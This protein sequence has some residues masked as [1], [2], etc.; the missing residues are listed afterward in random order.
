MRR[1]TGT[2]VYTYV[3][4][5]RAAELDLHEDRSRR[6]ALREAEELSRQR[7]R[8]LEALR[9]AGLGYAEPS[10]ERDDYGAGA[11]Q[12][13][14]LLRQGVAGVTQG[15]LADGGFLGIPDLLRR[16][17]GASALGDFH[18][19][20]GDVKSS[21]GARADQALQ[22]AFYARLLEKVQGRP[23]SY[24]FLWLKDGRE[25]RLPLADLQPVL[26]DVLE[27]I[28]E[29]AAARADARRERPFFQAGCRRCHWSDLCL[30]ELRAREDLSLLA[31][32]TRGLR[33]TLEAA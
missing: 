5:P 2:T 27:R 10:Y 28:A 30:A 19:V 13:L 7:G 12:T 31:G 9:T 8:E 32:M 24:G 4:C 15:V 25:Q 22:V 1:I 33:A 23:P 29:L 14:A 18:Y 16:E 6:R 20:V 26:D 11:A 3:A 17:P 21:A